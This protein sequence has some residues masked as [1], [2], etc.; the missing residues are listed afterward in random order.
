MTFSNQKY[1]ALIL[2]GSGGIGLATAQK[3]AE[4]G[5][6]LC[7]IYRER[8]ADAR[9]TEEHYEKLASVN[10]VEIITFNADAAETTAVII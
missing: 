1:F 7:I 8:K 3:L 4:E 10:N 9:L 6:N 2:G 5:M